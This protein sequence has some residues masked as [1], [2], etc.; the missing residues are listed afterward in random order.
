MFPTSFPALADECLALRELSE[1]DI[2]PWFVRATDVESA[3][4][5]GDPVPASIDMGGPWLQRQRDHFRHG[6]GLRWAIVPHGSPVSVGTVGL[7]L[8]DDEGQGAELGIVIAR[9]H[10]G[11]GLGAAAARLAARYGLIGLGLAEVRAE[12]LERNPASIRM[13]E[14]AGFRQI[15]RLAPCAAEPEVMLRYAATRAA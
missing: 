15:A 14:K 9:A 7:T 6:T 13:L 2:P 8:G 10:W 5:A 4:L 1:E 12:V 11:R 3:D